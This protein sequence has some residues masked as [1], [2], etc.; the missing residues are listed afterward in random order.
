[1]SIEAKN[2]AITIDDLKGDIRHVAERF[3]L[4]VALALVREFNGQSLYVPKLD[5]I[6]K[7]ARDRAII[8][9]LKIYNYRAVAKKHNLTVSHIRNIETA[10]RNVVDNQLSLFYAS[11]TPS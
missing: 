4:D 9:D 6:E 8:K 2:T 1:M 10:A 11:D 3:G 5:S 7:A